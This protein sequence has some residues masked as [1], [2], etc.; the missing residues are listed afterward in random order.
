MRVAPSEADVSL[1]VRGAARYLFRP[2]SSATLSGGF[3]QRFTTLPLTRATSPICSLNHNTHRAGRGFNRLGTVNSQCPILLNPLHSA[4]PLFGSDGLPQCVAGRTLAPAW[5]QRAESA[6]RE[7]P[8]RADPQ[9]D[10][11]NKHDFSQLPPTFVITA[12]G[13][14]FV[15][16]SVAVFNGATLPTDVTRWRR[17]RS[18]THSSCVSP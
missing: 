8:P 10:L 18:M 11:S 13:S 16:A 17:L 5:V 15:S 6:V 4:H 1:R 7:R 2:V 9:L 3:C 14:H 12:M